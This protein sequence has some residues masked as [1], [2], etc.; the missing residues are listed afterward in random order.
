MNITAIVS[1]ANTTV[2]AVP[3]D[4]IVTVDGKDYIFVLINTTDLNKNTGT[5]K[6]DKEIIFERIPVAKGGTDISFTEITLLKKMLVNAKIV[7]KGAFFV[8]A[9]MTNT[10]DDEH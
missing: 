7:T 6:V 8:S 3:N 9:K 1:L 2:P 10:Q 4:A 5:N